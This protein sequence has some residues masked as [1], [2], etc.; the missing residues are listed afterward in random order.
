M[1]RWRI[2]VLLGLFFTPFI[3]LIGVGCYH[4]QRGNHHGAIALLDRGLTRLATVAPDAAGIDVAGLILQ[5]RH[6][7]RRLEELGP[8]RLDQVAHHDFPRIA[9]L[10]E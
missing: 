6:L 2:L 10:R 4:L 7:R 8:R 1:S 5:A 3:F 9:W